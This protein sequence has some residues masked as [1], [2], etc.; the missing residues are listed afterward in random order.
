[1][2]AA[3]AQTRDLRAEQIDAPGV[4]TRAAGDQIEER[5]LAGAVRPDQRVALAGLDRQIDAAQ[6]L[7]GAEALFDAVERERRDHRASPVIGAVVASQSGETCLRANRV[8]RGECPTAPP[9]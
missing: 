1:M 8:A 3:G 9:A 6:N 7:R 2:I 5:R 4:R